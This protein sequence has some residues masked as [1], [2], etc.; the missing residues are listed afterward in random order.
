MWTS[1]VAAVAALSA[2]AAEPGTLTLSNVRATYG[3][4]GPVRADSRVLPGDSYVVSFDIEGVRVGPDGK[5]SYT[6]AT[7][8]RNAAGR[9]QDQRDP[10]PVDAPTSLGGDRVTAHARLNVGLDTPPGAV[11][12]KVTVTDRASGASKSLT[13]EVEVLPKDFGLIRLS[14]TNDPDG[15]LP[16]AAIGAGQAAWLQLG[17]VGFT[18]AA[19]GKQPAVSFSLRFLDEAGNPTQAKPVEAAGPKN[20]EPMAAMVPVQF[21]LAPNRPGKFTAVITATDEET[22]KTATLSVP[23]TVQELK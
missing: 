9:V 15:Q 5:V 1:V 20:L 7:E 2:P 18:R 22:K 23:F 17:A 14:I 10:K 12:F 19:D 8:V 6:I 13:K 11:S 16:A 21:V 4:L 3:I